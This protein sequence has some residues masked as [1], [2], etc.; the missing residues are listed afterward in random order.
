MS[1]SGLTGARLGQYELRDLLGKGG[2]GAVYRGFQANLNR[3][4]AIKV[5]AESL[6]QQPDYIERFTREAMTAASL[7]HPQIIPVY[8]YG[9]QGEISYVVMR[10]LR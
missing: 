1:I 3:I 7:E 2:M 8:D 10:L 5:L 9:T 6:A 4:V